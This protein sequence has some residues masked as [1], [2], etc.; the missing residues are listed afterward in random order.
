[1]FFNSRLPRSSLFPYTTLF[2]SLYD[3]K[4]AKLPL[5]LGGFLMAISCLLFAIFGLNLTV[6][7]I[8]IIYGIMMLGHRMSFSNTLAEALKV[9]SE[10]HTSELQS[11][12]DI[13]CRLLL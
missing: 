1:V 12:F 11:R 3:K 4:G 2:R 10:E 9:R 8:I 5:Y 6:M 7:M 13:V